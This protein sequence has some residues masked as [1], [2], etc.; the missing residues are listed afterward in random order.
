MAHD[1]CLLR[2]W[3]H[4]NQDS[5]VN[6]SLETFFELSFCLGA[7][8]P[9]YIIEG[10]LW[11]IRWPS[12]GICRSPWCL[13]IFS[14]WSEFKDHSPLKLSTQILLK[15]IIG[16]QCFFFLV[17]CYLVFRLSFHVLFISPWGRD[18]AWG[19]V[20]EPTDFLNLSCYGNRLRVK[21]IHLCSWLS[22]KHMLWQQTE[23]EVHW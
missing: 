17:L 8:E 9:L 18:F 1:Y 15:K 10:T 23:S 22:L 21:Y 13:C 19:F 5:K 12:L 14:R 2:K 4:R 11:K 20:C 6:Q 3:T 7:L 16:L